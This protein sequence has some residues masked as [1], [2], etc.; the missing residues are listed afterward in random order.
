MYHTKS[1]EAYSMPAVQAQQHQT[2]APL[3]MHPGAGEN[4]SFSHSRVSDDSQGSTA[5][6]IPRGAIGVTRGVA[7][8]HQVPQ[9]AWHEP[10]NPGFQQ[11]VDHT[12][13]YHG[14]QQD[15]RY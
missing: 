12:Q 15:P 1:A 13:V 5:P 2:W 11:G 7:I 4:T 10:Y 9:T 14:Y 6:A 3:A 8:T